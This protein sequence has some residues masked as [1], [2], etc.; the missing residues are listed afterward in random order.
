MGG[1]RIER[2]AMAR[3]RRLL[4]VHRVLSLVLT[5][6]IVL[7]GASGL[8][9]TYED[10]I[11]HWRHSELRDRTDGDVGV[12]PVIAAA[13]EAVPEA[14]F[15]GGITLPAAAGGVYRVTMILDPQTQDQRLVYVDPGS[16]EVNG[17]VDAS[18]GIAAL[19]SRWHSDL[20][21]DG[22]EL[23][24]VKARHI[25]G[26]LG[27]AT[28][29][30]LAMGLV[31]WLFPRTQRWRSLKRVTSKRGAYTRFGSLHRLTGVLAAPILFV[32]I[33]ASLTIAFPTQA[34][35]V[36]YAVTPGED[37][38]TRADGFGSVVPPPTSS[39]ASE[40]AT[41]V[42]LDQQID[43]AVQAV[44]DSE[45]VSVRGAGGQPEGA[46]QVKLSHGWDP[47]R[48]PEGSGG[49]V[50]VYLDQFTGDVLRINSPEEKTAFGQL[51]EYWAFAIHRGTYGGAVSRGL[52][53]LACFA[54]IVLLA[55]GLTTLLIRRGKRRRRIRR[56]HAALPRLT[57]AQVREVAGHAVPRD[58]A[59]GASV[60]QVGTPADSFYI[61]TK[62]HLEVRGA[63]GSLL[64]TMGAGDHFGEV[65]LLGDRPR[66]ASVTATAPT[67]I[68]VVSRLGFQAL[69]DMSELTHVDLS[70]V[71]AKRFANRGGDP[72]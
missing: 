55:T 56:V 46:V 3:K 14:Q 62:G 8:V 25:V 40:G 30:V 27:V 29:V 37:T 28:A 70:E 26:W 48:G 10:Q 66:S 6:W 12:G 50:T 5:V 53:A 36:F 24:G 58:V 52:W 63:D 7:Q 1:G 9:M 17:V 2:F 42:P 39:P 49:N 43:G 22:G 68:L 57:R 41:P 61:V 44:P 15:P 47:A 34:R 71:S 21:Q 35:D 59:V 65:G 38:G 16:G 20:L 18:E 4:R 23:A 60:V 13:R 69:L 64:N 32:I 54:P 31:L 51:Y 72:G 33:G 19:A 67:E 45:A 11:R